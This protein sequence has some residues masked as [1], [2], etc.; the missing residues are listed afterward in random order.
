[1][2]ASKRPKVRWTFGRPNTANKN[3]DPAKLQPPFADKLE[4]LFQLMW[5]DPDGKD[6]VLN[7]GYRPRSRAEEKAAEG[8]GSPDS[9]HI[10]G[11]AADIIHRKDAW[12]NPR[13]FRALRKHT[14]A[15]GLYYLPDN[16]D[17]S[18]RDPAH[19]QGVPPT[20]LAQNEV[21]RAKDIEAVARKYLV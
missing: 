21:R 4:R 14:K 3:R 1:M 6:A 18:M 7:E 12:N 9:M 2:A 8:L 17:G 19:V 13:F 5:A 20:N 11:L 16:P 10:Y 15:V